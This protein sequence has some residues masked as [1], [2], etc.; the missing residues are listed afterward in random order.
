MCD[1]RACSIL[2][3]AKTLTHILVVA[4]FDGG[5]ILDL[6]LSGQFSGETDYHFRFQG[7]GISD[8]RMWSSR[9]ERI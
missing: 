4:A 1:M 2:L 9:M 5:Y 3:E 6:S 7:A 8:F